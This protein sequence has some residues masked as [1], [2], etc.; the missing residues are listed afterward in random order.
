MR[1]N[2]NVI[3]SQ[4]S[5]LIAPEG[6]EMAELRMYKGWTIFLLIAPEGIE[7]SPTNIGMAIDMVS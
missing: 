3:Y 1:K 6:I 7:M 5:L 4:I 2:L